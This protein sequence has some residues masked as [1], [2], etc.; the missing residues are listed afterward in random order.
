MKR[1]SVNVV[2]KWVWVILPFYIFTFLPLT[3]QA[4]ENYPY[5]SDYLWVTV[6]D[7]SDWLYQ[8]GE[9]ASVEVQFY[10]YG[11]PR[12]G[13]VE[14]EVG[15]DLLPSDAKGSVTLKSGRAKIQMGTAKK[16]CFRDLRLKMKLD[17]KT[18][19]HHVKVG[20][21]A[22][23]ILPF[24]QEPKDFWTFWQQNLDEAKKF[25]MHYTKEYVAEMS[26]DKVECYRMKI[27][28]DRERHSFYAYLLMPRGAK[29]GSCPVVLTPPGAGVKTIKDGMARRFWPENGFIRMAIDIH[30]LNP[31]MSDQQWAEINAAFNNRSNGYLRQNLEDRNQYYMKHVYLGLVRA[32][33][34]L[35]SLPEWDGRHVV[36][37]GGSQGGALAL[38]ATALDPRVTHCVANH[39]ALSDMAAGSA[40]LTSGYPHFS[41]ESGA[42]S[43][44]CMN[45]LPYYDVV[46]FARHIKAPVYMT[47]GYNDNTCPPT[48]SY[49]VWNVLQCEKE[50]LLTPINE[51]W[52]SDATDYGQMEWVKKHLK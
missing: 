13:V 35:V 51:H 46:N 22:D 26:N 24:T 36:V 14:W 38:I 15:T 3:V 30:G 41:K 34:I 11:I 27:D 16:P 6:P 1:T 47:W 9:K 32:I 44:A 23:K 49:A 31:T 17:G 7:H 2:R 12:D 43:E 5:R 33:D 48:T 50:S 8:C 39:P 19:E 10:K 28:L 37:A 52:T 40:G 42:Y 4:V 18:Y 45:S 25:L 20:F 29:V 21:S